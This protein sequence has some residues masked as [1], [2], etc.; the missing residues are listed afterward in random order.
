MVRIL[1]SPE[2]RSAAIHT[3]YLD[4][5][6]ARL[7]AGEPPALPEAA[8]AAISFH[9]ESSRRVAARGGRERPI[10]PFDTIPGWGVR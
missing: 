4:S 3:G 5:E 7:R 10:D 9:E 1:D 6:G 8:H 2:F